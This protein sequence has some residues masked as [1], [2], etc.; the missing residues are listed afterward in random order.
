MRTLEQC[1]PTPTCKDMYT[2]ELEK[3][4]HSVWSLHCSMRALVELHADI[5]RLFPPASVHSAIS[6]YIEQLSRSHRSGA[7]VRLSEM[8]GTARSAD[9]SCQYTS[10]SAAD[11][12]LCLRG[13]MDAGALTDTAMA[14]TEH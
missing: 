4:S 8:H 6:V 2:D 9:H 12:V 5:R 11:C 13:H 1:G 10:P 3:S 7:G 14:Y